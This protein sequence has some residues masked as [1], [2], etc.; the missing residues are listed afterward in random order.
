MKKIIFILYLVMIFS[1]KHYLIDVG[2]DEP[3]KSLNWKE[4]KTADGGEFQQVPL[5]DFEQVPYEVLATHEVAKLINL[6]KRINL[7]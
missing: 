1:R 6:K 2:N 4:L 5:E 7:I 3:K